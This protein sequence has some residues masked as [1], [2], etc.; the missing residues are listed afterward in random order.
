MKKIRL[1]LDRLRVESFVADGETDGARG[2]VH[3]RGLT[4]LG[5]QNT[6]NGCSSIP[7]PCFCTE[8]LSCQ[9]Q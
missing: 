7:N 1:E 4:Q 3:G 2:T 5:C 8:A 6:Y 9:C